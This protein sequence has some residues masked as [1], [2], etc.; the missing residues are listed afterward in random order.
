LLPFGVPALLPIFCPIYQLRE[1]EEEI[2]NLLFQGCMNS[3]TLV[4]LGKSC[5]FNQ[6][7][8]RL[9]TSKS[10]FKIFQKRIIKAP[11]PSSGLLL[12]N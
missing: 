3:Q 1:K 2:N 12:A 4:V 11:T 8:S 7:P 9:V 6:S 10:L 5:W